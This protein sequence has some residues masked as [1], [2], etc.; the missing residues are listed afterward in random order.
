MGGRRIDRAANGARGLAG[1][2]REWCLDY[3]IAD[4]YQRM[5][6]KQPFDIQRFVCQL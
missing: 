5:K 2:A 6:R 3:Y 4:F 1:S